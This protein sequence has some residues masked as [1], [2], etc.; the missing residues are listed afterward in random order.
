M[1]QDFT[2]GFEPV[3]SA[4]R[5]PLSPNARLPRGASRWRNAVVRNG[6]DCAK[7]KLSAKASQSVKDRAS[8]CKARWIPRRPRPK[9]RQRPQARAPARPRVVIL[10][11]GSGELAAAKG[12]KKAAVDVVVIDRTINISS[13]RSSSSRL[14]AGLPDCWSL[15]SGEEAAMLDPCAERHDRFCRS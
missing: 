8:K 4:M 11:A 3:I 7:R 1:S 5:Q 2:R 10:G 9:V 13:S 15:V 14:P 12:L 6:R